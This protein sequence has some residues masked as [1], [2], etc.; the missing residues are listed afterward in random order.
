VVRYGVAKKF[1][2]WGESRVEVLGGGAQFKPRYSGVIRHSVAK[3][4]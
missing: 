4:L 2:R 3:N 1:K